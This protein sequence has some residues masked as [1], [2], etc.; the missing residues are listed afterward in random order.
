MIIA[1]LIGALV[2][3]AIAGGIAWVAWRI[4]R[5]IKDKEKQEDK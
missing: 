3:L 1:Y 4:E 2:A 5:I